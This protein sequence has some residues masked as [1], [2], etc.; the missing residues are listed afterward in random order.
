MKKQK[1]LNIILPMDLYD[2]MVDK[3][4]HS[5]IKNITTLIKISINNLLKV[6]VSTDNWIY[7]E[8]LDKIL[9]IMK[10]LY[11]VKKF[12]NPTVKIE[13]R[14][15]FEKLNNKEY[16]E[17]DKIYINQLDISLKELIVLELSC[18]DIDI[19]IKNNIIKE[20]VYY[21]S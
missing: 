5:D 18:N 6:G 16:K 10:V 14:V 12:N 15:L 2:K 1:R 3:I 8:D 19:L 20:G 17:S 9:D 4:N 7:I 11:N 13:L 21:D